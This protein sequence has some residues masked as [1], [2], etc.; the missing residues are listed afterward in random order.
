MQSWD[1]NLYALNGFTGELQWTFRAKAGIAAPAAVSTARST[2]YVGSYD[3]NLYAISE[4]GALL[5]AF[6]TGGA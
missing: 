2:V 5:W 4:A 1:R 3:R 6:N